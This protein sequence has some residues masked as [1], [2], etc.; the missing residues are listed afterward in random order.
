MMMLDRN[1][2]SSYLNAL[3][4]RVLIF[5][6]PMGTSLASLEL[7]APQFGG[8]L[9]CG[10]NDCLVLST[11]QVVE[12]VHRSFLEVG[13]DVIETNTFRANRI[14]LAEYGIANQV[15]EINFAAAI[16]ARRLADE[17]STKD[18]PRFVAGSLGPTGQLLSSIDPNLC[19]FSF[20][21]IADVYRQQ[22][23]SLLEGGIDLFL[24]ET[25]Q[26]ILE[27]KAAILGIRSISSKLPIQVQVTLDINGRMLLGT[28]IRAVLAILEG[29]P[30][31]V[32]GI[33]CST[34]PEH[35]REPISILGEQSRLPISCLPNAGLPI[36]QAGKAIYPLQPQAFADQLIEFVEK[37]G[38]NIVGGCCGTTPEHL[39]L[40]VQ[41]LGNRPAPQRY[42]QNV[43][44]LSS[45]MHALPIHQT[46]APLIIGER[47]N[48]QGSK[49]FKQ[50]VLTQDWDTTLTIARQQI[51]NGAHALDVCTALT[52]K[53]NEVQTMQHLV[54]NLSAAIDAPLVIDSTDPIVIEAALKSAPGRCLINSLN[55]E[56]GEE[57]A[58]RIFTLARQFNAAIICL[59]IDEEGMAKTTQRKLEIA[60]RIYQLA[61]KQFHFQPGDLIF[62]PLTFTLASGDADS[63][64]AAV[65][66]LEAIRLIKA[67]LPGIF[68][69]LGVS[70]VSFGL[71]KESRGILNSVFLFHALQAGLD[72]A[73]IN[74]AQITPY[75]E[76]SLEE[77]ELAKELIYNRNPHALED[78][79]SYFEKKKNHRRRDETTALSQNLPP[80]KKI[81]WHI[82]NRVKQGLEKE[83]DQLIIYDSYATRH[84]SALRILNQ[85]LL[86]AMQKVGEKFG[87][88][89]LILPFVLQSAEVM[90]IAVDHLEQYLIQGQ[91]TRKGRIV[92]ATVYGDVHDIG[93]NLVKTILANNGYEVV[94][95]GKQVP[96]ELI[97][98]T[99]IEQ[100]ADAIGLSALLVSTSQQM[101][102]VAAELHRRNISIPLL[103]GGAAIN[104]E[105][106]ARIALT[107]DG[108]STPGGVYY[109]KDAFDA[110]A[111][112][113][114]TTKN[115]IQK[116]E[117]VNLVQDKNPKNSI[118]GNNVKSSDLS[119]SKIGKTAITQP[120][121]WGSYLLKPSLQEVLPFID[122]KAL[123][124][125]SWGAKNARG[126]KWD[127]LS[128][129]FDL[130]FEKM[131]ADLKSFPWLDLL[132]LYGYW[133]AQSTGNS[134]IIYKPG[135]VK[136]S[137]AEEIAR[138]DFPRQAGNTGLC[139]ADYFSTADSGIM[140]IAP[141]QVVS[142]GKRA[143]DYV[144]HL[145]ATSDIS[146]AYFSHGLA[147]SLTEALAEYAHALIRQELDLPQKQGK[148][149]SW[150]YPA[151]PD[152]SQHATLFGFLPAQKE[153]GLTL[154][155]GFQMSPE[156]STAAIIVVHP[157]ATYFTMR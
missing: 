156:L 151:L 113:G 32:I 33:N 101:A 99:A 127:K 112:L 92:L 53:S 56:R 70:N 142:V 98:Q 13:V 140:D 150:G 103:I 25:A 15:K 76:I 153:L 75:P 77:K 132:V 79:I 46:P 48:T 96:A 131:I 114:I 74:P 144:K 124:R 129:D 110:L 118:V 60:L 148:R 58:E 52:E 95:L 14:T 38:I 57:N 35:M 89:E 64:N 18:H 26:D 45:A 146:E 108:K 154:T 43:P 141:F 22:A 83:L 21:E 4:K 30:I 128:R 157:Q 50:A 39:Q 16:L 149:F 24:I 105:F 93:K 51:E 29:L 71:A 11:P 10:C 7:T 135:S 84:E 87:S 67:E 85:I 66:T 2:K 143:V 119:S 126:E 8:E 80:I 65:E 133:P 102:L 17:F 12:K 115:K 41:K 123:Y 55:L 42:P 69:S 3:M 19:R 36:S 68:T 106:A 63:V 20:D 31:D 139:L 78:Y 125:L 120:P 130:R 121:F 5:D 147:V 61:I 34:G 37:F 145:Y 6:G 62:D 138:F 116:N 122:K 117:P 40:L 107:E 49:E 88:G 94:D 28:D 82:L 72:I 155:S 59:T 100:S 54:K 23:Q 1:D 137:D 109:C 73:I 27:V 9:L 152:L 91:T 104:A 134:L 47:L 44:T 81:A 86:P 111:V 90:K 136:N 97:I